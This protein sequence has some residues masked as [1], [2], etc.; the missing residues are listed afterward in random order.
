MKIMTTMARRAR[1]R[2]QALAEMGL[3]LLLFVVLTFGIIDFGRMLMILNVI[4]HAAR[5]GARV[6]AF[7]DGDDWTSGALSGS[8]LSA[9]QSR[10]RNQI[11]TVMSQAEADAF[12]VTPA[13]VNSG[14]G[15]GHEVSV[16]VTG[17]VPFMFTFPGLW[18]GNV[19][20]N[21]VATFRLEGGSPTSS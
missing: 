8:N 6:A 11:A 21:R 16:T 7:Y 10:V 9:V 12:S 19:A 14:T 4:T 20:V 17:D 2:G 18:G 1:Q 3:V 5:D 13:L 15:A